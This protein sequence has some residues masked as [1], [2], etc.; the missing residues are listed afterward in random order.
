MT[1]Q[2][3]LKDLEK[4]MFR[5]SIQD[6]IIDIQIG[7][8]LLIFAIAP[9]L[10]RSLGD[11]WSSVVFLPFWGLLFLG[12]RIIRKKMIEPRV[13][14]IEPGTYRKKRL[15]RLNL[16]ILVFNIL[17]LLL[18]IFSFYQF[19]DLPGWVHT[20]RFSIILLVGFSLAGYMLEFT[21][22][23]IYGILVAVAPLIGEY[24]YQNFSFSHHG[25][26]ITFGVLSSILIITGIVILIQIIQ[27][28]PLPDE[29]LPE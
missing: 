10:S 3:S 1:N 11:F 15:T 9:L 13:G 18:G 12:L 14:K 21:R 17:A 29:G 6:G 27:K 28:Y 4:S 20:A 25:F 23:Y 24:L 19:S 8:F 2:I 26:P 5:E 16:V 22:L 7:A